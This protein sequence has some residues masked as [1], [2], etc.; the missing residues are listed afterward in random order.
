MYVAQCTFLS[1]NATVE[2]PKKNRT[3][4]QFQQIYKQFRLRVKLE[5]VGRKAA[6]QPQV[7]E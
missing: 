7:C 3:V 1:D 4:L 5:K 2:H 6:S